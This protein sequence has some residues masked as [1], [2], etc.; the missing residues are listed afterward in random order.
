MKEFHQTLYIITKERWLT[1]PQVREL[2]R[3]ERDPLWP[4]SDDE[5]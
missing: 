2:E 5:L 3:E 1:E 4:T